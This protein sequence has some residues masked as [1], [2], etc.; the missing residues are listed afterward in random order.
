MGRL[1]LAMG[2]VGVVLFSSDPVLAGCTKDT[3]CKGTRIC[4]EGICVEGGALP[5]P[6]SEDV[7]PRHTR[8]GSG[9]G[10]GAGILGYVG[11]GAALLLA[12]GS[13]FTKAEQIPSL[14]LGVAATGLIAALG[15]VVF[16]GGASSRRA[17]ESDGIM[18]M[19][20]A[21]WIAY[22][23]SLTNAV[24]LVALGVAEIEPVDG[25]ILITGAVGS[26]GLLMLAL[27][28]AASAAGVER[29]G[30]STRAEDVAFVPFVAPIARDE[31]TGGVLGLAGAF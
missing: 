30:V 10:R 2:I 20:I 18:G 28:A 8:R 29:A 24:G 22:G 1:G 19:R 21:G 14:P 27:D 4:E 26:A 11:A 25:L 5:A 16:S 13:E 31:G 17:L 23:L 3:D 15:P 7:R 9:W 12:A 6:P